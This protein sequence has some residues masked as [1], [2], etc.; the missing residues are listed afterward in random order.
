MWSL[1]GDK[2]QNN[3]DK[4]KNNINEFDFI[5]DEPTT[6]EFDFVNVDVD[7]YDLPIVDSDNSIG[8]NWGIIDTESTKNQYTD[9]YDNTPKYDER[10]ILIKNLPTDSNKVEFTKEYDEFAPITDISEVIEFGVLDFNQSFITTNNKWEIENEYPGIFVIYNSTENLT[11]KNIYVKD[12]E[13]N[14]VIWQSPLIPVPHQLKISNSK[15]ENAFM[16]HK[17]I[18]VENITNLDANYIVY[19]DEEVIVNEFKIEDIRN[20]YAD[21]VVNYSEN[22][23]KYIINHMLDYSPINIEIKDIEVE[24]RVYDESIVIEK[25]GNK[26]TV[27][28]NNLEGIL[29]RS[30][31][32]INTED[33]YFDCNEGINSFIEKVKN[34]LNVMY[35]ISED[36]FNGFTKLLILDENT[37]V[38]L[39][40]I[41]NVNVEYRN[42]IIA[43]MINSESSV[44][45]ISEDF[46][47]V[48]FYNEEGKVV[49]IK[50]TELRL[51]NIE[52]DLE[53]VN[54]IISLLGNENTI[55]LGIKDENLANCNTLTELITN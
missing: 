25:V 47:E 49:R 28:L 33:K 29:N 9:I 14:E 42:N 53:Q 3:K 19:T 10:G 55:I 24:H 32:L 4:D 13:S 12:V 15:C 1:I 31:Y 40:E 51:Q 43:S 30:I 27:L 16:S 17:A 41:E 26:Y 18:F 50:T 2:I 6:N 7:E 38:D 39:N 5:S 23:S 21:I 52:N 11:G 48:T 45:D 20:K 8:D 35:Q 46:V 22:K 36:E 34:R 54:K 37:I 44:V